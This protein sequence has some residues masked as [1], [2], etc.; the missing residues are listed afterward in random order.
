MFRRLGA[1]HTDH[2]MSDDAIHRDR[3]ASRHAAKKPKEI[4]PRHLNLSAENLALRSTILKLS[5]ENLDLKAA[6]LREVIVNTRLR[7]A[8]KG[9]Q[10]VVNTVLAADRTPEQHECV[11]CLRD[12]RLFHAVFDPC[13]HK[14]CTW[15]Y[16]HLRKEE[17]P[18]CRARITKAFVNQ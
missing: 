16:T 6:N 11:V 7:D 13:N 5:A 1:H 12:D 4:T 15:C 10:H 2:R 14:L 8:N 17:C 9:L 18:L 3:L